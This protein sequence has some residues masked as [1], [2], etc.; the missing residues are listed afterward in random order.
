M[1]YIRGFMNNIKKFYYKYKNLPVQAR[2]A[3]IFLFCAFMQKGAKAITTPV[4]SRLLSTTEYG[5][6]SVFYSWL[7]IVTVFV[8]LNLYSGVYTQG[9]IKFESR[10]K[11]FSSSLQGLST[12]LVI[13]WTVIYLCLRNFWNQLLSLTTIQM[14][15]MLLMIWLNSAFMFWYEEQRVYYN[16]HVIFLITAVVS[17]LS[18]VFSILCVIN[19]KDKVTAWIF[20]MLI[21]DL[22]AYTGPYFAQMLRGKQF[23]SRDFWKYALVF[24]IPLIPH[25]LSQTIL[26]SSDKIMIER[27]VSSSE[28]G[29]Y[30]LAYTIAHVMTLFS[31]ALNQTIGPWL[32]RKIRDQEIKDI[33]KIA[34]PSIILIAILNTGLIAFAPEIV[35]IFAPPSYQE[36]IWVIPP[37]AMSVLLQFSYIFF[38]NFEFY[39]EKTN[40]I[41]MAT[42]GGAILNIILNFIFIDR[43]GYLAAG[44]TTLFC[45]LLYVIFHYFSMT[46]ICKRNFGEIKVYDSRIL[47]LIIVIFNLIGFILM[48]S[49]KN[50]WIRYMLI[51]LIFITLVLM[52]KYLIH[53]IRQLIMIRK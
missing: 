29:I 14:L 12:S 8:S 11:I 41:A 40:Y 53:V 6:Y 20:G 49:Y 5:Q 22:I 21:V 43:F 15:A 16:Y 50:I 13:L 31:T 18:P 48:L 34:Y 33:A 2:A 19:A 39:F 42:I 27:M 47:I 25:Y 52:R 4:L 46:K 17:I 38:A 37:V 9:L 3:V 51:F 1:K 30:S 28:A 10:R 32:Y 26:N 24:N 35:A 45:F 7:E 23:F 44:Y 36:A